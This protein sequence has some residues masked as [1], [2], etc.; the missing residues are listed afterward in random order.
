MEGCSAPLVVKFADT[1]KEKDA[2][3]IQQMQSSLWNIAATINPPISQP[4]APIQ[5]P[6]VPNPP[7]QQTP[8]LA[9]DAIS[10][11]SL[12]FLQQLQAVGLQQQLLQ[13]TFT[14]C[15]VLP[16]TFNLNSIGLSAQQQESAAAAAAAAGL[17][18]P[19]SVQNLVTLAAMAQQPIQTAQTPTPTQITN[20]S[21]CE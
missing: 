16:E 5:T 12:Q 21:L 14:H 13:G 3:R 18:G 20:A 19:M 6:T 9:T 11:T 15:D 17:L 1:Q 4:V 8:F 2:K 10:P 7:T